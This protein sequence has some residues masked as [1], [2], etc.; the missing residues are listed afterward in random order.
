[1][2]TEF[3][4]TAFIYCALTVWNVIQKSLK[5]A[6]FILVNGIKSHHNYKFQTVSTCFYVVLSLVC[7]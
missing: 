1:M 7:L 3:G 2:K 5:L 4:N 6:V